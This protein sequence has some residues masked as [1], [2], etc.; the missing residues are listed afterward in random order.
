M[1]ATD[2]KNLLKTEPFAPIRLGLSDGRS[3]LV[4]HPDQV[5]LAERHVLIGL[6]TLERSRPLATPRS[7]EAIARDW[8]IISLL[9]ISSVEPAD[10]G[11]AR[12]PKRK[13]RKKR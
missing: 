7:G 12:K 4:R 11:A 1:R 3:V 13:P 6:A 8:I 5:V 2:L 9:H 10:D